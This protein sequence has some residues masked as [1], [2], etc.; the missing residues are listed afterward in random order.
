[1]KDLLDLR[2]RLFE[3]IKKVAKYGCKHYEGAMHLN[4]PN[5]F[6]DGISE[7][8]LDIDLYVFG[9]S[10]RMRLSADSYEE[11]VADLEIWVRSWENQANERI[12]DNEV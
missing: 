12:R 9:P 7:W 6:E 3:A 2:K 11:L 8:Q 1:M 5:C 4:M 10:R